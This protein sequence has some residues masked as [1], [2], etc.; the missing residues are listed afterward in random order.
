[1][2]PQVYAPANRRTRRS[3]PGSNRAMPYHAAAG[4]PVLKRMPRRVK[5]SEWSFDVRRLAAEHWTAVSSSHP[6]VMLGGLHARQ[7][8]VWSRGSMVSAALRGAEEPISRRRSG[9]VRLTRNSAGLAT[10]LSAGAFGLLASL[11]TLAQTMGGQTL[12]LSGAEEVPPVTTSA[13]SARSCRAVSDSGV[14]AAFPGARRRLRSAVAVARA[15]RVGRVVE[16]QRAPCRPG[17]AGAHRPALPDR[18][19]QGRFRGSVL[20]RGRLCQ[21]ILR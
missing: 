2:S 1:M 17:S 5:L 12:V 10:L 13:K 14:N 20:M 3:T 21:P 16:V 4:I 19:R 8:R 7:M 18:R 6:V 11:A 15:R 9:M